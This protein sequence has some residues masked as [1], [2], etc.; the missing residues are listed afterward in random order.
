MN[1]INLTIWGR[2]LDVGV[3]Y[4]CYS[5]ETVLQYQRDAYDAF[6]ANVSALLDSAESKV[7]EYILSNSPE[8]IS[9]SEITNIFRYVKPKDI[10]IKRNRDE[11][12][13][14]A[15]MCSYKFNPE[16][17]MAIIFKDEKLFSIG[18]QNEIL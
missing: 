2:G 14:V 9:G 18:T 17:G 10:F 16:A 4:D 11:Q 1:K 3:I 12:H 7:K 8:E 15:L 13:I 5:G 6:L